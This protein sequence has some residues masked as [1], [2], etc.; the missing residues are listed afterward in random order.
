MDHCVL[1]VAVVVS[2]VRENVSLATGRWV[3]KVT[4]AVGVVGERVSFAAFCGGVVMRRSLS[5]TFEELV[6]RPS[7]RCCLASLLSS[8]ST[9]QQPSV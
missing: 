1:E 9:S 4:V 6:N 2:V 7:P 3:V 5:K 8:R